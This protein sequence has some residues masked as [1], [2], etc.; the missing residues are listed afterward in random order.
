M[1][2]LRMRWRGA[3]RGVI[4]VAGMW[5]REDAGADIWLCAANPLMLLIFG[6]MSITVVPV[7]VTA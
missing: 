1:S 4:A 5:M 2:L 7:S 3:R 6:T